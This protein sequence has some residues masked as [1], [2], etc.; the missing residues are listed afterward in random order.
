[1]MFG[2]FNRIMGT[3]GSDKVGRDEFG[4][5]MNEL[6]K[7]VLAVGT[8]CSPDDRLMAKDKRLMKR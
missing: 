3:G 4:T 5:L 7:G 2:M 1:M 8:G 6:V